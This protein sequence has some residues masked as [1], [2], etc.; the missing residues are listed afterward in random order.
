M[1]F[2]IGHLA[3]SSLDGRSAAA[4]RGVRNPLRQTLRRMKFTCAR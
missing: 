4:R 1:F 2:K 3:P